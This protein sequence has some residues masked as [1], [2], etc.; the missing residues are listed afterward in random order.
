MSIDPAKRKFPEVVYEALES[1]G[2]ALQTLSGS[3]TG[4]FVGNF[5]NDHQ[6]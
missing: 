2:V 1:G 3:K 5:N 6:I 4:C